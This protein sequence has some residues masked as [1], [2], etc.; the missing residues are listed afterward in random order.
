MQG[1]QVENRSLEFDLTGDIG[2]AESQF[3]RSPQQPP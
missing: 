3:A 2:A 1:K